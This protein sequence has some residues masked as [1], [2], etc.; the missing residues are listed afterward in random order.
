MSLHEEKLTHYLKKWDLKHSEKIISTPT[1]DVYVVTRGTPY[2]LK[3]FTDTGAIDEKDSFIALKA[4]QGKGAAQLIEFDSRALLIEK[5]EGPNLY[6]FSQKN[7]EH[8]ATEIFSGIIKKIHLSEFTENQK[9]KSLFDIFTPLAEKEFRKKHR[10]FEKAYHLSQALLE[11]QE[12]MVLLHGD[13]HHENV[14]RRDNGEYVCFDPK[15]LWGDPAYEIATILKN[16]WNY[17]A[18]SENK[19]A[20]LKRANDFSKTLNLPLERIL[21]FA[22]VHMC[23]SAIWGIQDNKSFDHQLIIADF[24]ESSITYQTGQF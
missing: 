19:E 16:P 13:L 10:L 22:F 4:W 5:L 18:V 14:M 6:S 2:I 3:I 7:E 8:K 21:A 20:C 12:K 24:L 17:P 15:G 11:S 23:L 9:L 1:S